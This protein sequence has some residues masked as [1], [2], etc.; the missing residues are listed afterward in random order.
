[1]FYRNALFALVGSLT[2]L[3]NSCSD[4]TNAINPRPDLHPARMKAVIPQEFLLSEYRPL[5]DWLDESVRVDIQE[6][7]LSQVFQEP[8]LAGL[9]HNLSNFPVEDESYVSIN[10][11]ALT[12]RQLL[13]AI[14][15]DYKLDMVPRFDPAGGT[16]YIDI[17][18]KD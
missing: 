9:N 5:N 13:W 8:A 2:V 1:M 11:L 14:G 16:S 17:R 4:I 6:V 3:L 15:Q 10:E 7:P 12:R 18:K